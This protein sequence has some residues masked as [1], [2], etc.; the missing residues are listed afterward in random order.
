MNLEDNL[1]K[2]ILSISFDDLKENRIETLETLETI[3]WN[4]TC[5]K[6]RRMSPLLFEKRCTEPFTGLRVVNDCKITT[7]G[8]EKLKDKFLSKTMYLKGESLGPEISVSNFHLNLFCQKHGL[9]IA[10]N[11][12]DIYRKN[13]FIDPYNI[14]TKIPE[15]IS[16]NYF[17]GE[18]AKW[19]RK[20]HA[21]KFSIKFYDKFIKQSLTQDNLIK[22]IEKSIGRYHFV[23]YGFQ[24]EIVHILKSIK[25]FETFLNDEMNL[26]KEKFKDF[27]KIETITDCANL[28]F[29]FNPLFK[30]VM[31]FEFKNYYVEHDDEKYKK[32]Y[33]H[34]D[35]E[36][37]AKEYKKKFKL[38]SNKI[39]KQK[40][41][42]KQKFEDGIEQTKFDF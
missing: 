13:L 23:N 37:N 31:E 27:K 8:K 4:K 3:E 39:K 35:Y 34:V 32:R 12:S 5:Y 15:D 36:A 24:R 41:L 22:Q 38:Q 20:R 10:L 1:I 7:D 26:L 11:H 29:I 19:Y 21:S 9:S 14:N 28:L 33:P 18:I 6:L 40:D 42:A 17:S 30:D 25:N 2:K 16:L